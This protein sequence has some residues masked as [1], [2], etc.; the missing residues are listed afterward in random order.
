MQK[1]FPKREIICPICNKKRIIVG[2]RK[3]LL[4]HKCSSTKRCKEM[5]GERNPNWKGGESNVE[6]GYIRVTISSIKDLQIRQWA[7]QSN[8]KKQKS[9]TILKHRLIMIQKLK[10]PLKEKEIVHHLNGDKSDNRD[11]NLMIEDSI[12]HRKSYF[13]LLRERNMLLYKLRQL[14]FNETK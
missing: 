10:R 14:N 5:V 4:C 9:F 13:E 8:H 6:Q 12:K 1:S 2:F 7:I 3:T 11:I